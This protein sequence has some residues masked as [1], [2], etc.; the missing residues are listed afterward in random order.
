MIHWMKQY[1][2]L[3]ENMSVTEKCLPSEFLAIDVDLG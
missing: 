2:K 3:Q 1:K